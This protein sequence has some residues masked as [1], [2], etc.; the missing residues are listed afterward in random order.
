MYLLASHLGHTVDGGLVET[1]NYQ[2]FNSC[3]EFPSSRV[4][5]A[6]RTSCGGIT[7]DSFPMMLRLLLPLM[8]CSESYPT[9]Q[10]GLQG[11]LPL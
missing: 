7:E 5:E 2:G 9:M 1:F 8:V 3:I 4:K 6:V 10:Y 11:V